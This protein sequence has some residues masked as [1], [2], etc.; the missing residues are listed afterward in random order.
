MVN[1]AFARL[2]VDI[3]VL[4]VVVKVDATGA[5]ITAK[6]GRMCGEHSSDIDMA[7]PAERY[8]Y[9]NLPFVEMGDYG[10]GQLSGDVL[11]VSGDQC[12][13]KERWRVKFTSPRNHATI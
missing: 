13:I 3:E 2:V 4:K 10:L 6:K 11:H 8:G 7:F 9:A 1:A 5:E 12:I